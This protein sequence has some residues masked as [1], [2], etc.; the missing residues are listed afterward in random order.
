MFVQ[1]SFNLKSGEVNKKWHVVDANGLVVGRLAS[2]VARVLMGKNNPQYTPHEDSGDFVVIVNAEKV[3]F[4]GN[5][6]QDKK[7]F[8]HSNHIGGIKSRTAREQFE[9][10]PELILLEAIKGMLPKNTLGRKQLTKLKVVVGPE[11][12]YV[13]QSPVALKL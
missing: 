8:W 5:K 6:L 13:A 2:K 10:H 1:R 4:T 12:P 7:Y 3:I 9:K 11:H